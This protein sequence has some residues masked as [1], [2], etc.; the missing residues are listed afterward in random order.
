MATA[1]QLLQGSPYAQYERVEVTFPSTANADAVI[2]HHLN[3]VN[4]EGVDY[5]ILRADRAGE[6][7]HDQSASRKAWGAG[8]IVLRASVAS[9]KATLLLT[10]P[11]E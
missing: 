7:Y 2:R 3:V 8:F 5:Q 1:D 6:V 11:R 10:V 4:P 9:L